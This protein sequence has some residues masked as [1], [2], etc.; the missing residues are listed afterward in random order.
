MC[1]WHCVHFLTSHGLPNLNVI[2][3]H[4]YQPYEV[5]I[6]YLSLLKSEESCKGHTANRCWSQYLKVV[7]S[8]FQCIILSAP[9]FKGLLFIEHLLIIQSISLCNIV[10]I[11]M[12]S[13][14][15]DFDSL[16]RQCI[17]IAR[18]AK[19]RPMSQIQSFESKAVLEHRCSH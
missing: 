3:F 5:G 13:T 6:D 18:V 4:L 9:M 8:D 16:K 14:L 10:M 19:L 12:V 17:P 11:L 15:I 1:A 7:F 2:L